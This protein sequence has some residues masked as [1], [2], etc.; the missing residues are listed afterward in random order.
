MLACLLAGLIAGGAVT[1][2]SEILPTSRPGEL[3]SARIG[4]RSRARRYLLIA[5]VTILLLCLMAEITERGDALSGLVRFVWMPVFVLIAVIDIEHRRVLSTVLL[6]AALLALLE[7]LISSRLHSA[8]AGG[9]MGVLL[10]GGMY[11]GGQLYLHALR[12][13]RSIELQVVPFGGGDV[14][15]AGLCGL[16]VGW[17]FILPAL[18]LAVLGAGVSALLLLATGRVRLSSALPYAPFLL[19]GTVLVIRFPDAFTNALRL[20][21]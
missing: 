2:L 15:L 3:K 11:L 18:L 16:V 9:I 19:I 20:P 10:S 1:R 17:P 14:M 13:W 8:L 7:S 5:A 4:R 21:G 12:R 6:P